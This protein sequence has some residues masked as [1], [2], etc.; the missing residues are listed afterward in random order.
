MVD[1]DDE[2]H[3]LKRFSNVL[4]EDNLIIIPKWWNKSNLY[5]IYPFDSF[6]F[7]HRN[8]LYGVT[9]LIIVVLCAMK[10]LQIKQSSFNTREN[11]TVKINL[12][13][14]IRAEY[15]HLMTLRGNPLKPLNIGEH[16]RDE[17][18][19]CD[20]RGDVTQQTVDARKTLK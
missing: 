8:N 13:T 12:R 16:F 19:N 18:N 20:Q 3:R 6:R 17:K 14:S 4:I 7:T 11:A 15:L 5:F 9:F 2:L 1:D 10:H